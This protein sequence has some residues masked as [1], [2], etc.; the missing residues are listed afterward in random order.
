MRLY[1]FEAKALLREAH[2]PVTFGLLARKPA[3][4]IPVESLPPGP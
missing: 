1:E 3:D 4:Q 2:I